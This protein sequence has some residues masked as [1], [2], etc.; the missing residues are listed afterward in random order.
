M[1]SNPTSSI[2][3]SVRRITENKKKKSPS[4]NIRKNIDFSSKEGMRDLY[5][6]E[7]KL[8]RWI[9]EQKQRLL[10]GT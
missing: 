2:E 4:I 6:R 9:K 1:G 10:D 7:T 8:L 3:S 5:D